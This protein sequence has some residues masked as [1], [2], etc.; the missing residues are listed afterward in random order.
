MENE[1]EKN[2]DFEEEVI[3]LLN[4]LWSQSFGLRNELF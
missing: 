3:C 2:F 1:Q 4:F